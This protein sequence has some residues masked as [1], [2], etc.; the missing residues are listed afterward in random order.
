M[1]IA[2]QLNREGLLTQPILYISMYIDKHREQY[3][4]L[5]NGIRLDG[6]GLRS[7]SPL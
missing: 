7:F 5:L 3:Y 2:L 4:S 1:L 6:T